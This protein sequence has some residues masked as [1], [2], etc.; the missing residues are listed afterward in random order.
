MMNQMNLKLFVLF[1]FC[2]CV[3]T[4]RI[5]D[6]CDDESAKLRECL[7]G[8]FETAKNTCRDPKTDCNQ[9][10]DCV[11]KELLSQKSCTN[12]DVNKFKNMKDVMLKICQRENGEK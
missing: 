8:V 9:K 4:A 3:H 7:K 5:P 10:F 2:L 6:P 1:A 11:A 12:K